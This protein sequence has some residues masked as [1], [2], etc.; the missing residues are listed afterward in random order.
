[1]WKD[2]CGI[3]L[4]VWHQHILSSAE[5]WL[6]DDIIAAAQLLLKKN[7]PHINGLRPPAE[8][9]LSSA[10][11]SLDSGDF[12]QILHIPSTHWV[13]LSNMNSAPGSVGVYDSSSNSLSIEVRKCLTHLLH[14]QCDVVPMPISHQIGS[15]DCGLYAIVFAAS[16]C[17]GQDPCAAHYNQA[18]M[19]DHLRQCLTNESI[20]PFPP[21]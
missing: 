6:D 7:H 1:M 17:V 15:Y 2:V 19:R 5:Q 18:S 9:R 3:R 14:C 13:T 21:V 8:T 12:I 11:L 16:L 20:F 4:R 10:Q